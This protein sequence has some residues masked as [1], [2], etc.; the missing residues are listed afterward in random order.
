MYFH[1]SCRSPVG[2]F[3]GG[4]GQ[5]PH[6]ATTYAAVN[7]L[8]IIGT[9]YALNAIDKTSLNNFLHLVRDKE[10]GFMMHVNGE[11]DVRGAYCAISCAKLACFSEEEENELFKN[12]PKWISECQTY[13]GG[14]G[15]APDLEAHGGYSFCAISALAL[16]GK[17]CY[18]DLKSLLR[19]TLN[20][21]MR[22]EGGFQGRTNKLVDGC[23]SFWQAA[24]IP[25]TQALIA[26]K[27][28]SEQKL[29]TKSLFN[30]EALQEYVLMCCQNSNGGLVDKPG[31]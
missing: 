18:C 31:K 28:A 19:W 9:D 13:E 20:R 24:V 3:G 12:T 27:Y 17:A 10:G 14:F 16:L 15:G 11:L 8:C 26:Q 22:F 2:G 5:D 29:M 7:S 21:Q 23:Y 1:Y 6:L 25:V 30:R 4:P